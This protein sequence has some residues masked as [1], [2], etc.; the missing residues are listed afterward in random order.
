MVDD[1]EMWFD[2]HDDIFQKELALLREHVVFKKIALEVGIGSGRFAKS[3]GISMGIDPS[4]EMIKRCEEKK[5]KAI[6]GIAEYLPFNSNEFEQVFYITSLCFVDDINKSIAEARR[7]LATNGI[8]TI[9]F[10]DSESILGSEIKLNRGSYF[11]DANLFT[12]NSLIEILHNNCFK[13]IKES[14]LNINVS[15]LN[16]PFDFNV[17]SFSQI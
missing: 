17:L 4:I 13:L 5:I 7:V 1:Y 3:L 10:I 16:S 2:I 12:R 11:K 8:I 9:A 15:Q 14:G 6:L